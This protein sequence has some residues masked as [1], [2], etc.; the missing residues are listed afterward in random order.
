VPSARRYP[1]SLNVPGGLLSFVVLKGSTAAGNRLGFKK[2]LFAPFGVQVRLQQR[3]SQSSGS[4]CPK[5]VAQGAAL[6][7]R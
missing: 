4:H 3:R 1:H 6:D 5:G 7:Q 2:G